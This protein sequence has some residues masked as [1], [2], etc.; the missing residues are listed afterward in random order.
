M[1]FEEM[2]CFKGTNRQELIALCSWEANTLLIFCKVLKKVILL[3]NIKL[4]GSLLSFS[5]KAEMPS[6]H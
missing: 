3:K 1:V 6:K 2:R 5:C 4:G